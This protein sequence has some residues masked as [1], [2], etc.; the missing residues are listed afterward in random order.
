MPVISQAIDSGDG[1]SN[2]R[3]QQPTTA[4]LDMTSIFATVQKIFTPPL[5]AF[6]LITPMPEEPRYKN[7]YSIYTKAHTEARPLDSDDTKPILTRHF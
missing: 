6:A 4:F 3:Q 5:L 7:V 2:E 1:V